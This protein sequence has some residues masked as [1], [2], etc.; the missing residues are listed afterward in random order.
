MRARVRVRLCV[1]S[2]ADTT[3]RTSV[4]FGSLEEFD[5]VKN[6]YPKVVCSVCV[7]VCV[8]ARARVRAFVCVPRVCDSR[9][10]RLHV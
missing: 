8:C 1:C 3:V 7:C 5:P 10:G 2:L 6:D 9:G 4:R